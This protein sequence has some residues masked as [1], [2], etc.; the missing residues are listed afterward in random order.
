VPV[1]PPLLVPPPVPVAPPV[2]PVPE[3][4]HPYAARVT[5]IPR[6][7]NVAAR[8]IVFSWRE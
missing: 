3:L 2:P 8:D 4:P 6:A 1:A 7:M 5:V